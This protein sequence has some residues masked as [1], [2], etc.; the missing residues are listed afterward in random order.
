MTLLELQAALISKRWLAGNRSVRE[1]IERLERSAESWW[2]PSGRL[3]LIP[4]A[5]GERSKSR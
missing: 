5:D 1:I 3:S 2:K 4:R